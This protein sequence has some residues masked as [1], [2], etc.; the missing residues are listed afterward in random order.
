MKI[1]F[2]G[3]PE[4]AVPSLK[5]LLDDAKKNKIVGVVSQPSRPS[6]R[7]REISSPAVARFAK[8]NNLLLFQPE[9]VKNNPE[10]LE[11]LKS[12]EPDLIV[13]VAYGKILPKEIL[14]LPPK[15]CVNVHFS[16]LPKYRGA[17]PM[18]W[19]MIHEE[20]E[21][22][23]TTMKISQ[24]LDAG[25]IYLQKKTAILPEDDAE[26]LG[27]RLAIVGA[28]LLA[29]TIEGIESD[30]LDPIPQNDA[31]ATLAPPLKKEDGKIDWSEKAKTIASKIRAVVPWPGAFT[32]LNGKLLKIYHASPLPR[33]QAA[34]GE[35]LATNA[36]GIEIACAQ[37]AL[38]ITEL[39]LEGKRRMSAS[40][41][42]KGHPLEVGQKLG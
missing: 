39:Q 40:D 38:L 17:A 14:E 30:S 20:T 28:Q 10:F 21:T 9:K 6:G 29:E 25:D 41:F 24:K 31:Q 13:V 35:I 32:F 4:V 2:M 3:S 19:A 11:I 42:L 26:I 12:L 27:H 34:P 16:L 33:K 15:G 36:E 8:E 22:G 5:T 7:G 18:Q 37:D 23:V 1:L